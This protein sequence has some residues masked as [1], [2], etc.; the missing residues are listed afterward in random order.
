VGL[1]WLVWWSSPSYRRRFL[2]NT[3]AA[4]LPWD[5]VRPAVAAAGMMLAELPWLWMRPATQP[6][7]LPLHW[8]GLNHVTEALQQGRGM[9]LLSPHLGCWELGAQM[10]AEHLGP[11]HGP[12]WVMYRPARKAW[13]RDLVAGSR[14][15]PFLQAAPA[16]QS[17]VRQLLR[18]LRQGGYTAILPD[19]VP[20]QGQGVWSRFFGRNVY[21]ITLA[22]RLA[23]Q[24]GSRVVMGWC[25]R[26]PKGQGFISH[27]E[28]WDD[29]GL[30]D[31]Q[32]PIEATVLAMNQ[33]IE[34]MV[35]RAP[36]QYLW[37]YARDKQPR[38][39]V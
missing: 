3:Q 28:P 27:F 25:E 14:Q 38:A 33:R 20:P 18:T 12:M 13:L 22:V 1:G 4:G 31:A 37:G 10:M 23:R 15:R 5:Q 7:G 9:I 36:G 35:R 6:L 34:A 32:V 24:T 29:V 19:Q 2:Q 17:G 11:A 8:D 21:T 39:E 26:L 16:N 30:H